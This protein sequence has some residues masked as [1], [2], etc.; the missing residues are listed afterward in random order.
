MSV[1]V[2]ELK[3]KFESEKQFK[4]FI[5]IGID[6]VG[7]IS[8]VI[9]G[10]G[11]LFDAFLAPLSAILVYIFFKKKLKWAAFNFIEEII[12]GI[13]I[14]PSATIAWYSMYV[15]D[16]EATIQEMVRDEQRKEAA[17]HKAAG[18]K[19]ELPNETI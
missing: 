8:Y 7:C 12:P 11:E 19:K 4:L 6:L 15:K 1:S 18:E 9:P 3:K 16:Q 17:F 13:D 5:A 14:I 2:Q 10:I